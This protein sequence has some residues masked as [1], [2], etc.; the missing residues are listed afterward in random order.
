MENDQV[1][2]KTESRL[3][4]CRECDGEGCEDCRWTGKV[5]TPKEH[6]MGVNRY[7]GGPIV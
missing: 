7:L 6:F 4:D 1:V 2:E 5:A 3:E